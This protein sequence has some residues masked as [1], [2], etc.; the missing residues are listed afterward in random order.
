V[1][2]FRKL[3]LASKSPSNLIGFYG[4]F[5]Q[6]YTYNVIL[7]FADKGNLKQNFRT[8]SPPSSREDIVSFW[9]ELFKVIQPLGT[10]YGVAQSEIEGPQS[11]QGYGW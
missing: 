1:S 6:D 11:F 10:I 4:S 8:T 2:A 5:V 7:K 3:T 9:T